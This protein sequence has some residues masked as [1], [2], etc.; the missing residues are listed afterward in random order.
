MC[1]DFPRCTAIPAPSSIVQGSHFSG[2]GHRQSVKDI[3]ALLDWIA[4]QPY[5]DK[6]RVVLHGGSYS[7]YMVNA[8][9]VH[10]AGRLKACISIVAISDFSSFLKNTAE[11]RRDLRRAEYG[12]ERNPE[13][14][15]FLKRISPLARA[16]KITA[17]MFIVHGANDPR[18]PVTEAEQLFAALK[19]NGAKPWLM[20]AKDEGH[21]F[22]KQANGTRLDEATTLFLEQVVLGQPHGSKPLVQ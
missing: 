5:L 8:S 20:I 7:G 6:D 17:P 14:Q 11:Y 1:P 2:D 16:N 9:M 12:D 4:D 18:V 15:A 19:A 13:M 22:Q 3:G 21:G 10:F